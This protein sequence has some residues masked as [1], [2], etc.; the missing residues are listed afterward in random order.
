VWEV[1]VTIKG[2]IYLM[3]AIEYY[4][5]MCELVPITSK[6]ASVTAYAFSH[7]VLGRYG[8]MA[9]VITD[10]GTEWEGAFDAML[11]EAMVDHRHT[12]PGRPQS[13]GLAER[14]VQTVKNSL[15]KLL[16]QHPDKE[17]DTLVPYLALGYRCSPQ[18]S[19]G[20]SPY[21]LL[22]SV[23]P[24]IPPAVKER[25][26]EPLDFMTPAI[27]EQQ[28]VARANLMQERMVMAGKNLEIA[29]H[30]DT[31]RYARVRDGSYLPKLARFAVGDYVY[32]K[33]PKKNTLLIEARPLILRVK[34]VRTTGVLVLQGKCG[35]ILETHMSNCAPCHLLNVDGTVDHTLADQCDDVPCV[36]C[37]SND[38]PQ[39]TLLCDTCNRP[40][41]IYCLKPPLS[42]VP[43]GD[44]HCDRCKE[45]PVVNAVSV[46][47]EMLVS[48]ESMPDALSYATPA[49][50]QVSLDLLMPGKRTESILSRLCTAFIRG[51]E[52]VS[53]LQVVPTLVS[54][55]LALMSCVNV[56]SKSSFLDPCA[57]SGGIVTALRSLGFIVKANDLNPSHNW[58]VCEDAMQPLFFKKHPADYI[59]CSPWFAMLDVFLPLIVAACKKAC[60]VHVPGH[61]YT[62]TTPH[63]L[64]YLAALASLGRLYILSGLPVGPV[65]RRCLWIC[66]FPDAAS[67]R[68]HIR[69]G[70]VLEHGAGIIPVI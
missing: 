58:D 63:R 17:W 30:R 31:L 60:F 37:G 65:G 62:S 22:Y 54:E 24:T 50:F 13:D 39:K 26:T 66:V 28:L 32:V 70:S 61:Y 38:D 4:S 11:R 43:F 36:K 47:T 67:C 16:E 34:I 5:K 18:A 6:H 46:A 14:C 1:P 56:D 44:W 29:Q 20:F 68:R 59:V 40:F 27:V 53:E 19:T 57:G 7:N 64:S 69:T 23:A 51:M 3:V 10:Q 9:E 42:L 33:R 8:A 48:I 15:R 45:S 21:E 35:R 2:N 12:S 49:D 25:L 55:V 41:H 52:D